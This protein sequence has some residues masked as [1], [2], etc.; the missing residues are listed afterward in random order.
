MP[1]IDPSIVVKLQLPLIIGKTSPKI[2]HSGC[3]PLH[4]C[5]SALYASCP[6]RLNSEHILCDS[7]HAINIFAISILLDFNFPHSSYFINLSQSLPP[8]YPTPRPLANWKLAIADIVLLPAIP[9]AVPQLYPKLFSR[10]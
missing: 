8:R 9:S 3:P 2:C 7:S 1:M 10:D 6:N 5:I 4:S